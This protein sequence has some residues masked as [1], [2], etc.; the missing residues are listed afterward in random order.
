MIFFLV[1]I[2]MKERV[3]LCLGNVKSA[4]SIDLTMEE[5]MWSSGI[6]GEHNL[7]QLC[8]TVL[9]LIGINLAL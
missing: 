4:T 3:K 1:D 9:F 7:K 2:V 5:K 6:L 8:D